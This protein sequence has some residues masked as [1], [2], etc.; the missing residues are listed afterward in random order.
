MPHPLGSTR[1]AAAPAEPRAQ[2]LGRNPSSSPELLVTGPYHDATM[3]C[4]TQKSDRA[5]RTQ[6]GASPPARV[7]HCLRAA[8]GRAQ[9]SHGSRQGPLLR[10]VNSFACT[11]KLRSALEGWR[12]QQQPNERVIRLCDTSNHHIQSFIV[13]DSGFGGFGRCQVIPPAAPAGSLRTCRAG[14]SGVLGSGPSRLT[15]PM[16]IPLTHCSPF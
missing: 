4:V 10:L 11:I 14:S 16:P 15:V 9:L 5:S 1:S 3:L 6:R 7:R 13:R 12:L 2:S 8:S